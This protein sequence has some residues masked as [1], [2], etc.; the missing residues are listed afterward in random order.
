MKSFT[1][2]ESVLAIGIIAATVAVSVPLYK[3]YKVRMKMDSLSQEELS[4]VCRASYSLRS[5][6]L[7]LR[8]DADVTFR[9]RESRALVKIKLS[10]SFDDGNT[11]QSLFGFQNISGGDQQLFKNVPARSLIALKADGHR[12]WLL[13]KTANTS[14][15]SGKVKFDKSDMHVLALIEPN[16]TDNSVDYSDAVVEIV[17]EK[18][19][20][21]SVNPNL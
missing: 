18:P 19:D 11:W 5:G 2:V 3:N 9:V 1:L 4:E 15:G 14:D 12:G 21:R 16:D 6:K 20:C 7:V 8:E 17:M 10:A 13:K